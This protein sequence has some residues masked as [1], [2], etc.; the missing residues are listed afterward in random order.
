MKHLMGTNNTLYTEFGLFKQ[1]GKRGAGIVEI[2]KEDVKKMLVWDNNEDY[3]TERYVVARYK[4]GVIALRE[5]YDIEEFLSEEPY[6][7]ME[8][9]TFLHAKPIPKEKWRPFNP[10]ELGPTAFFYVL[11]D[12]RTKALCR[13]QQIEKDSPEIQINNEWYTLE[14]FYNYFRRYDFDNKKWVPAGVK[15]EK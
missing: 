6:S 13:I 8:F 14:E 1:K 11:E 4:N 7:Y 9:R 12:N 2:K 5:E 15:N 10:E 3:A